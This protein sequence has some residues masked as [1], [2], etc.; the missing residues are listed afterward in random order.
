MSGIKKKIFPKLKKTLGNF[1]TDESWKM[2]KKDALGIAAGAA[3]FSWAEE[4]LA[5]STHY[6][7]F[8]AS[9]GSSHS[10]VCNS[11]SN[12]SSHNNNNTRSGHSN[13]S[14]HSN[15]CGSYTSTTTPYGTT[16]NYVHNIW[17]SCSINH[18]SGV[19]NWHYSSIPAGTFSN[20]SITTSWHGSHNSY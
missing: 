5:V 16:N 15:S 4:A 2:T 1:L 9:G 20:P 8:I 10:N 12:G 7:N 18:G 14:P 17:G 3:L 11:H 19:V 13:T 6:N